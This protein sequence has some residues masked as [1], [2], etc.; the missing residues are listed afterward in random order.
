MELVE[1]ER[2]SRSVA[3]GDEGEW[4]GELCSTG[5]GNDGNSLS[6]ETWGKWRGK[7]KEMLKITHKINFQSRLLYLSPRY[8]INFENKNRGKNFR[9]RLKP[10]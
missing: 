4:S 7:E 10:G 9:S 3:L 8:H 5:D 1:R 6:S 2:A